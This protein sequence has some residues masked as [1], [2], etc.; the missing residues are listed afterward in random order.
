MAR[1]E[2]L[3]I[4]ADTWTQLTN[5]DATLATFQVKRGSI[6]LVATVGAVAP[7]S[8]S[9]ALNYNA[10]QGE[11]ALPM[12]SITPGTPGTNRLWAW[13]NAG[14]ADVHISHD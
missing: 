1:T 6:Q 14:S 5:S 10:G 9:Q 7:T 11:V 3:T 8:F 13:A 12:A 4:P 2:T